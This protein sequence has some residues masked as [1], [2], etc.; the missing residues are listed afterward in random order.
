MPDSST[1]A[2]LNAIAHSIISY[3]ALVIVGLIG[4]GLIYLAVLYYRDVTQTQHA[5]RRN[6]P[7]IGRFRYFFEHLGEQEAAAIG[8]FLGRLEHHRVARRDG[9]GHAAPGQQ[10]REIPWADDRN[11]P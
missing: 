11:Y 2:S 1:L 8:R 9:K 5:I 7:L 10:D 4:A 3:S 6:Y